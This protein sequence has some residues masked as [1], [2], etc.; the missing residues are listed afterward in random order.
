MSS[1]IGLSS[2]HHKMPIA[3]AKA[4]II[5]MICQILG[6]PTVISTTNTNPYGS[7]LLAQYDLTVGTAFGVNNWRFAN[8]ILQLS[9]LVEVP[10]AVTG[11]QYAYQLPSD[12]IAC[13]RVYPLIDYKIIGNQVW[14]NANTLSMEYRYQPDESTWPI[15]FVNFIAFAV[16][17]RL[18]YLVTRSAALVQ[19]LE[20]EADTNKQ[21]AL[22]TDAQS[23][24]NQPLIDQPYIFA[25]LGSADGTTSIS[26]V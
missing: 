12:Y 24:P 11:Y 15:Y 16:A 13:W 7:M 5:A 8:K 4:D 26:G 6:G 18:A 14:T 25:R 22:Y 3:Y 17:A 10:P 20:N 23:H 1:L 21:I 2:R 19:Q 9:Q